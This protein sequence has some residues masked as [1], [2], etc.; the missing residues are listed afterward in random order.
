MIWLFSAICNTQDIISCFDVDGLPKDKKYLL[1][2]GNRQ[3]PGIEMIP[4]DDSW[5]YFGPGIW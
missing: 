5:S 2:K 1:P 3:P 4:W